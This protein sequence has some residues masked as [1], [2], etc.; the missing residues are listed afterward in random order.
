MLE[1]VIKS[2]RI[3]NTMVSI[4]YYSVSKENREFYD[5]RNHYYE[6]RFS[7]AKDDE[8]WIGDCEITYTLKEAHKVFKVMRIELID[9]IEEI[10]C[11]KEFTEKAYKTLGYPL[12]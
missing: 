8:C 10:K 12:G 1:D 11:R 3:G 6:I 9:E 4:L 2:E 7:S 5:N